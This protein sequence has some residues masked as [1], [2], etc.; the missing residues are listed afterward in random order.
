MKP[1]HRYQILVSM[2]L[3]VAILFL[4]S[5]E[6]QLEDLRRGFSALTW[7]LLLV[8]I[9]F[10]LAGTLFRTLRYRI[11]ISGQLS[12]WDMFLITLVRNF[13]VD[14]LPARTA[15][16]LFYSYL[17][18]RKGISYEEGGSS[19][20]I[21]LF[22]DVLSL[23]VLLSLSLLILSYS[24]HPLIVWFNGLL[25]VI[26][27]ALIIGSPRVI[28]WLARRPRVGKFPRVAGILSRL[29]QYFRH[30]RSLREKVHL[31]FLSLAIKAVKY[32]GL[33]LIFLG[34]TPLSAGL[35]NLALFN[36]GIAGTELS[37]VLPVQGIA[38]F[39]TWEAAFKLVFEGLQS[40]IPNLFIVGLII[41]VVTQAWE[42]LVGI[43]AFL[44]LQL[45]TR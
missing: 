22:Y 14:L 7:P 15:S 23:T 38:G 36:I 43:S 27:L 17:T 3:T 39:G 18:H 21:A 29:D 20:V 45:K 42:Y 28:A 40:Q 32:L 34:I 2:L 33:Y 4:F 30:H 24:I 11:L 37:S 12:F 41:H 9:F 44:Y 5:R 25:F 8:F 19:F 1:Q 26:T 6:I 35:K 31:F 10:S 13:S 16:L